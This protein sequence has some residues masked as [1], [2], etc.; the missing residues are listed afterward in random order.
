MTEPTLK[1]EVLPRDLS[2]YKKGNTGVDYVHRFVGGTAGPHV[3]INA[4]THANG[5]CGVG[6][7]T[8]PLEF[9]MYYSL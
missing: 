7:A 6:A 4:L 9:Q 2:P 3:V 5:I 1:F 8:H